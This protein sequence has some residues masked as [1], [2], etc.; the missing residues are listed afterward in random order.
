MPLGSTVGCDHIDI[1]VADG[2]ANEARL[3]EALVKFGFTRSGIS[4]PLFP[5]GKT[6]LRMGVPPNRLEILSKIAGVEFDD[7]YARRRMMAIDDLQVSVIDYE[8]LLKNKR[9][10]GR[11]SDQADVARLEKRRSK[12]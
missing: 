12:P 10:T 7:C 5:E 4:L 6:V 8:D 3:L 2:P 11:D 9:S 1:W